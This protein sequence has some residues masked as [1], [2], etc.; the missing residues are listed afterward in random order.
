MFAC[1][2]HGFP[3]I[4]R[5]ACRSHDLLGKAKEPTTGHWIP[6]VQIGQQDLWIWMV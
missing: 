1:V 6:L 4:N 3:L 5:S 2:F